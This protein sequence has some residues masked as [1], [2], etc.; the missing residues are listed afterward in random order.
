MLHLLNQD[1]FPLLVQVCWGL[2]N[3]SIDVQD[4]I[5]FGRFTRRRCHERGGGGAASGF[6]FSSSVEFGTR[7][8]TLSWNRGDDPKAVAERFLRLVL[9]DGGWC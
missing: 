4:H 5:G 6:D 8:L 7:Q 1:H 2:V 9:G 3:G